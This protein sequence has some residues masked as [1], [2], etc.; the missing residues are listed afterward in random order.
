MQSLFTAASGLSSQQ[1][2]L[3][4]LAANVANASTPGYKAARVD[5]KDALYNSMTDPVLPD[6]AQ[7]NL[8]SGSGVIVNDTAVD[9]SGGALLQTGSPLDMA[10]EGSGF[11]QVQNSG[12]EVFYTRSGSFQISVT[13]TGNYLV[14]A[15]GYFVLNQK[16][17]KIKLPDG[18]TS[19]RVS[20]NGEL[21]TDSGTP[22]ATLGIVD[23]ANP[24]GLAPAGA[25]SFTATAATGQGVTVADAHIVQGSL[26]G[27]N[28]NLAQEM[29]LLIRA[30]RAYS[31]ASRAL[32]TSDDMLGLANNM[33]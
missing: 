27:S 17:E 13:D 25:T 29:T 18:A 11:F 23:F 10:I 3:E 20:S 6:S 1:K 28:V 31:L 7:N 5:F 22:F 2:R 32:Q 33:H 26:E 21:S 16:G 14:T 24:N 19:F 15:E 12:G 4:T 8:L 30:Q 9:Y